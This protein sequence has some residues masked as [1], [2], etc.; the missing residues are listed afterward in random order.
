M[1]A[2][3][4]GL[5]ERVADVS[6][7]PSLEEPTTGPHPEERPL[8]R[9]SKDAPRRPSPLLKWSP[10]ISLILRSALLGASRRTHPAAASP[11]APTIHAVRAGPRGNECTATD[12]KVGRNSMR[13]W[14]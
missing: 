1:G 9:V 12:F 3:R 14:C 2:E 13:S 8:G 6:A 10:P 5:P 11:R 7:M 4:V